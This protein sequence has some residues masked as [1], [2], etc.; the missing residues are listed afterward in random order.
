MRAQWNSPNSLTP[1]RFRCGF[2]DSNVSSNIGYFSGNSLPGEAYAGLL[3]ICP[4][5]EKPSLRVGSKQY[6]SAIPG[7]RV[8]DVPQDILN[9]YQEARNCVGCSSFTGSVLC[10]RKLLMNIAVGQGAA[11]GQSFIQYV[12]YLAG[13]GYVPPNGKGW[14]DHIRRRGNEATHEIASMSETDAIELI[15][16]AEML[17]KFI[18]E[19]PARVPAP[20]VSP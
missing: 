16:F 18:Y 9:L 3:Y 11:E 10:S 2:C 7:N 12:E 13:A 6:P 14:V 4:D 15:S 1:H 20:S 5:C 19:F 17:L 8:Q